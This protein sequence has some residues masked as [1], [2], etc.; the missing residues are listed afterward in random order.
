[1]KIQFVL[2]VAPTFM[3]GLTFLVTAL[4]TKLLRL[5]KKTVA[6]VVAV[7]CLITATTFFLRGFYNPYEIEGIASMSYALG[8]AGVLSFFYLLRKSRE[9]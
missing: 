9:F 4:S 5:P 7:M 2:Q 3:I 1:M 6:L 8:S